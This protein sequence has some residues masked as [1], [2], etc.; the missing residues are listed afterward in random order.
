MAA[1]AAAAGNEHGHQLAAA[2]R[3]HRRNRFRMYLMIAAQGAT[4]WVPKTS[5]PSLIPLMAAAKGWDENQVAM[6][7]SSFFP[8]YLATQL[9]G[10]YL[11]QKIGPKTVQ[12]INMLSTALILLVA[13]LTSSAYTLAA[14]LGL[15]GV[16]QGPF[17]PAMNC[18]KRNWMPQGAERAFATRVVGLGN[19]VSNILASSLT[20]L[21]AVNFGWASVPL[22][23]GSAVLA[24]GI[25]WHASTTDQP[26]PEPGIDHSSQLPHAPEPEPPA[27]PEEDERIRTDDGEKTVE[28]RI[29]TVPAVLSCIAARVGFGA[30]GFA[31]QIWAPSYFVDVLD[32]TPVQTGVLLAWTTPFAILGDFL[33]ATIEAALLRRRW[34]LISIRKLA[35]VVAGIAQ[36]GGILAFA[37]VRS[38]VMAAAAYVWS[39]AAY[40]LHHSGFSANLLEVGGK[41][42]AMLNAV[43]NVCGNIPAALSPAVG[44]TMYR[45]TGSWVPF[46]G[47]IA[48][49]NLAACICFGKFA[50]LTEARDLLAVRDGKKSS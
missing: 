38:P 32:C 50:S 39:F 28:W 6:L 17:I 40:G 29:F 27:Q 7:L 3:A 4:N 21:L 35:T 43:T 13:P 1:A 14:L 12:T 44:V 20:P 10:S 2:V 37:L 25:W 26:L 45:R 41:D 16:V 36:S 9:P 48:V 19:N 30:V 5:L 34:S 47:G 22:V 23:Y 46:F 11:I 31:L 49:F 18:L 8:G 42:T 33:A 15:M 24:F